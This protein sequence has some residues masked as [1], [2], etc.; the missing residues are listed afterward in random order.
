MIQEFPQGSN[1]MIYGLP[2]NG[3]TSFV[4]QF[5]K[6]LT[7]IAPVLYDFAEQKLSATT[8]SLLKEHEAD[9]INDLYVADITELEDLK[10]A[11]DTGKFGFCVIDLIRDMNVES[12]EFKE[13][14]DKY[15]DISFILVF[16]STK[17]GNFKGANDWQ[18]DIDQIIEV[19]KFVAK[20]HGRLGT[21]EFV[22]WEEGRKKK[23]QEEGSS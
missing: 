20:S 9:N 2:K 7:P 13:V 18:H 8:Q 12:D 17:T 23:M 21:G 11:L 10:K 16:S 1:F 14:M 6:K 19:D 3:K 5:V 15:S 22:I 4:I